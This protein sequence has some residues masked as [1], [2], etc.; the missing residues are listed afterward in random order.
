ME[1]FTTFS[2]VFNMPTS[3]HQTDAA[4]LMSVDAVAAMLAIS[5][6]HVYRLADSGRMPR[7][8]KLGGSNRWDR[9]VVENWIREGCPVVRSVKH[10]RRRGA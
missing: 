8:V 5:T 9:D 3:G 7:P 4:R 2:G 6:R 1:L 10:P